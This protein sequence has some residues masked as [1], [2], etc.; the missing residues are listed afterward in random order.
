MGH[1][2]VRIAAFL[3]LGLVLDSFGSGSARAAPPSTPIGLHAV[4]PPSA[5]QVR[6][7]WIPSNDDVGVA[8]Y[9]VY[10]NGAL[11]GTAG[12]HSVFVDT[13]VGRGGSYAY[14]V[15][16]RDE[17]GGVSGHSRAVTAD[18][19]LLPVEPRPPHALPPVGVT[20]QATWPSYSEAQR[21]QALDAAARTGFDWIRVGASWARLQPRRP[22]ASD[23][24]FDAKAVATLDSVVQG[25][26]DR[27]LG[28][29]LVLN[30]TPAWANGGQSPKVLPTNVGDYARVAQWVAARYRGRVQSLEVYNEPNLAEQTVATPASY[31]K[32][33]CAAYPALHAGSAD[34]IVVS[35]ATA[36]N[37]WQWVQ[38]LYAA[39]AK[40]CFDAL[41]THPY[42]GYALPP[43]YPP[44]NQQRW[45]TDNVRK[46]R[47]VMLAHGDTAVPVWFT[48]FGWTAHENY[49]GI[50]SSQIGVTEE[51]QARYLV[52]M[53][54][55]TVD[56]YPFVTRLAVYE[57]RDE[58]TG[59][60]R[61]DNFGL[62]RLD[63]TPKPAAQAMRDLLTADDLPA[64]TP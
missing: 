9:R 52:E 64:G 34:M 7:A 46:V 45:W 12:V 51:E 38:N 36:G 49:P 11:I 48:E 33:L 39:G 3:A 20:V 62:F 57:V 59:N 1:S 18:V 15:Q 23:S 53:V 37:D 17:A 5:D 4:V 25:G 22:T 26:V 16:A 63:M 14:T 41:G 58:T 2:A 19:P 10:R 47:E 61:N 44:L 30:A 8:G 40:G 50:K 60:I 6:L 31:T 55:M 27:G 42:Q 29:H 28:V 54:E 35:G 13:S 24:G 21:Q 32:L 43:D 56:R